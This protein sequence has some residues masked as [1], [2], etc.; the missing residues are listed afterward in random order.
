[1]AAFATFAIG[2]IVRPFGGAIFGHFGDRVGRKTTLM[3]SLLLMGIPTTLIGLVPTY[4][5]IGLWA[6]AILVSLRIL[7]GFALLAAICAMLMRPV[8]GAALR[9][10]A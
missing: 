8:Q 9:G 2:L 3:V 5:S 6:A 4:N 1:M 7:Q 10:P